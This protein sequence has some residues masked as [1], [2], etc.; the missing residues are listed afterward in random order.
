M[1]SQ[2][3]FDSGSG[4]AVKLKI[5][6]DTSGLDRKLADYVARAYDA[7]EQAQGENCIDMQEVARAEIET[8]AHT[9]LKYRKSGVEREASAAGA[10]PAE[11]TGALARDTKGYVL[12]RFTAILAAPNPEARALEFGTRK[13][14]RHPFMYRARSIVLPRA[15]KRLRSAVNAV[16]KAIAGD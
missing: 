5:G 16:A 12:E 7:I 6:M 3:I 10:P 9:G 13:I 1:A 8:A 11:Q 14:R 4:G 15:R 2:A